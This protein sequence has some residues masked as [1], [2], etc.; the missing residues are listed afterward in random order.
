MSGDILQQSISFMGTYLV[1]IRVYG[2]ICQTTVFMETLGSSYRVC[3]FGGIY[4]CEQ[5]VCNRQHIKNRWSNGCFI[6]FDALGHL[7]L[8]GH[9]WQSEEFM[10]TY[11]AIHVQT[12]TLDEKLA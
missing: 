8:W 7:S 6:L 10:G 2:D 1:I 11:L 4:G 12:G 3:V 5:R 9:I